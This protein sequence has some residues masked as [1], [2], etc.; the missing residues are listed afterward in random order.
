MVKVEGEGRRSRLELLKCADMN[1]QN[2]YQTRGYANFIKF[3]ASIQN[4]EVED[5]VAREIKKEKGL[6]KAFFVFKHG[7]LLLFKE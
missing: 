2:I 6:L 5:F 4:A 3:D 1:F 7:Q